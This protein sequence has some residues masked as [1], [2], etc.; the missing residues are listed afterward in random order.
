MYIN[1]TGLLWTLTVIK[2][3]IEVHLWI[4]RKSELMYHINSPAEKCTTHLLSYQGERSVHR[5]LVPLKSFSCPSI[6]LNSATGLYQ[7]YLLPQDNQSLLPLPPSTTFAL[8]FCAMMNK[9]HFSSSLV[10][11]KVVCWGPSQ[12]GRFCF[13]QAVVRTS[14]SNYS[15]PASNPNWNLPSIYLW[16]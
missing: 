8:F 16:S 13:F 5:A 1:D 12:W 15:P 2:K 4:P 6:P 9:K 11:R 14:Q 3:H 10:S 7:W